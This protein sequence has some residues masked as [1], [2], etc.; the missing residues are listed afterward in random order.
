MGS[1]AAQTILIIADNDP[2]ARRLSQILV[3][4]NLAATILP[5]ADQ[6]RILAALDSHVAV[7]FDATAIQY[8]LQQFFG[9]IPKTAASPPIIV[10]SGKASINLAVAM[11]QQ[12]AAD[13]IAMPFDPQRLLASVTSLL[14][15]RMRDVETMRRAHTQGCAGMIGESP[16]MLGVFQ[17]IAAMANSRAPVF[18]TGE[19][20]TGKELCA[21]AVHAS[22]NRAKGPF[23]A[24]NCGA[25]PRDL[26]ESEIFGHLKG[27]FTGAI[28]DRQGAAALAHGGTL[29][30][31]EICEMDIAQQ[32]KL[33]RFLQT[34]TIQPV[35][36]ALAENVDVRI[37]CATNR[38]PRDEVASGRFREDLYFRLH[39]LAIT[40][41]PLRERGNDL[42]TL[43]A[44]FLATFAAEERKS[45]RRLGNDT[46]AVLLNH[47]WPGNVREL[48]NV[49]RQA[50]VLHDGE[51]LGADMLSIACLASPLPAHAADQDTINIS[52]LRRIHAAMNLPS[53]FFT[54]ELWRI[55]RDIIEGTVSACGGSVPKAAQVLGVSPSTLYRKRENW[56][57]PSRH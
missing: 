28:A 37:I 33:L 16:A 30:L 4:A 26:I 42:L 44:H 20:G 49:V 32:I 3:E 10:L 11:M 17:R 9:D 27:S 7:I 31:D 43:A 50:V 56:E 21:A 34:G 47:S 55:E 54:R 22:G 57:L 45:F 41:P 36:S 13:F 8:P 48:Q 12:G 6:R 39:V 24:L 23:I 46:E 29:F 40:M 51:E 14:P 38:N 19:T 18:I 2:L 1:T 5:S 52:G 15:R 25:I 35:G 53:S